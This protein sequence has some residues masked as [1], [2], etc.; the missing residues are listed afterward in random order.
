MVHY[1][2]WEWRSEL[3]WLRNTAEHTAT[4]YKLPLSLNVDD[5]VL[6]PEEEEE[7][8]RMAG[9]FDTYRGGSWE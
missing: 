7:L 8:G 2:R 1:E 5:G 9:F 3:D 4:D 6:F